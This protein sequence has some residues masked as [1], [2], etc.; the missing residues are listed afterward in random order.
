M[1]GIG[2]R[3]VGVVEDGEEVGGGR[4]E[5]DGP[6]CID[7]RVRR[8]EVEAVRG[9]VREATGAIGALTRS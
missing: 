6:A 7:G 5:G 3:W 8:G 9:S 1:V 4:A 2:Q